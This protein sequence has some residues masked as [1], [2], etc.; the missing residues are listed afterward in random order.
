[1]SNQQA[2]DDLELRLRSHQIKTDVGWYDMTSRDLA[3]C[4]ERDRAADK[5]F[6]GGHCQLLRTGGYKVIPVTNRRLEMWRFDQSALY[7]LD[8]KDCNLILAGFNHTRFNNCQFINCDLRGSFW[9][10]AVLKNYVFNNCQLD[11]STIAESVPA[12]NN[13]G[14]HVIAGLGDSR[15]SIA[16]WVYDGRVHIQIG[17]TVYNRQTALKAINAAYKT[18]PIISKMYKDAVKLID[19]LATYDGIQLGLIDKF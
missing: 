17:C 19:K 11:D 14:V 12:M 9:S 5:P 8:F 1:M 10:G 13:R 7:N 15:R 2:I 18:E 6:N 3:D 16:A 4:L